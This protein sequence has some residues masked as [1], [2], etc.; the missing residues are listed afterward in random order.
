MSR[1]EGK[2]VVV[3]GASTG[4]GRASAGVM[5]GQGA[6]LLLVAR[7]E[8][9]LGEACE[10]IRSA[11]GTANYFV[12]DVGVRQTTQSAVARAVELYGAPIDGFFANAGISGTMAPIQDYSDEAFE[13]ILNVNLR[14]CFWALKAVLPSMIERRTGSV[15]FTGSLA[16]ERGFPL[17][18]GYVATKHG[19]LGLARSAAAEVSRHNVRVN[20]VIPGMIDTPLIDNLKDQFGGSIETTLKVLGSM[21]PMQ[22]VGSS[23]EVGEVVAFLMSDAASY[24]TG[25][26]WSIDGG[27]LGTLYSGQ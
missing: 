7:S 15:V 6:K 1:L 25:Q 10:A 19:L 5:A 18:C 22:R 24:V 13:E 17:T 14:S 16:S 20:V 12:G 3:T 27:I 21:A 26:A 11:G 9:V 2:V 4:I 8:N 23:A